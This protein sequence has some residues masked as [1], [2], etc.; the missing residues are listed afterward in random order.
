MK[1]LPAEFQRRINMIISGLENGDAY[2]DDV[3]I[4]NDIWEE[5]VTTIWRFFDRLSN[6]QLT[7]KLNKTKFFK[8]PL[9]YLGHIMGQNQVKPIDV[10]VKTISDFPVLSYR[11]QLMK[12]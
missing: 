4:Y 7:I 5:Y 3:I 9:Q 8:S 1:S 12:F 10:K 11:K 6:A 2:I